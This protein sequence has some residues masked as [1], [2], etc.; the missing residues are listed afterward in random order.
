MPAYGG[1]SYPALLLVSLHAAAAPM[2]TRSPFRCKCSV[3]PGV[4]GPLGIV[5][6][7]PSA[8][9]AV[10]NGLC[11]DMTLCCAVRAKYC[12]PFTSIGNG[13][14]HSFSLPFL[15]YCWWIC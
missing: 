10:V 14:L 4:S 2:Q 11:Y 12:A 9:R 7:R 8:A 13:N 15:S 3:S 5:F 6:S 1:F